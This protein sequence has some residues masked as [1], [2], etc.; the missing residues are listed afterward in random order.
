MEQKFI[1]EGGRQLAGEIGIKG[2][3]NAALKI[4]PVAL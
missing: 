3:K 2:A 1:I 4:F